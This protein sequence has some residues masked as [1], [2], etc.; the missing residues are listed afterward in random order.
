MSVI[1]GELSA[2]VAGTVYC[3][4]IEACEEIS[5]LRR[6]KEWTEALT[7]WCDSQQ[8]MLTFNGQC[9]THR[10]TILR[11]HGEWTAAAEEAV[12]ACEKFRGAADEMA[13]GRALYQLAEIRRVSGDE[14]EAEELYRQASDW[15]HDP[16]PGLALLRLAQGR[17][18]PAAAAMRRSL[19]E[20]DDRFDRVRLLPA[21][22]EVMLA[23]GDIDAAQ[24][25]AEDLRTVAETY[26]TSALEAEADMALGAVLIQSGDARRP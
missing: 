17:T 4:L 19:A 16:Q 3:S 24:S 12:R 2:T 11:R 9:L 10:A 14:E 22:V 21:F 18:G 7:R 25:G 20:S 13:T 15:G 5:E 26:R 1:S 23:A 6:A 8:G